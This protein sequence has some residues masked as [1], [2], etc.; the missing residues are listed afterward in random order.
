MEMRWDESSSATQLMHMSVSLRGVGQPV[1]QVECFPNPMD[2]FHLSFWKKSPQK[3]FGRESTPPSE[4]QKW[5]QTSTSV[6]V[7]GVTDTAA[8]A[9]HMTS[10]SAFYPP[11]QSSPCYPLPLTIPLSLCKLTQRLWTLAAFFLIGSQRL[12][13]SSDKT[14]ALDSY[15]APS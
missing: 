6:S 3:T 9:D 5:S 10:V 12:K 13:L 7:Q 2:L 1:C 14:K 15:A 11:F 4:S 8:Q